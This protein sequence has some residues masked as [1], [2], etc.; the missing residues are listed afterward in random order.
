MG[1]LDGKVVIVTGM[2]QGMGERHAQWCVEQGAR[3][4]GT[5]VRVEE[6]TKA[7]TVLGER[8][9][10]VAHDV[11]D[12]DQWAAVVATAEGEWGRVDGLVNNAAVI[13]Y[14][15]LVDE[16]PDAIE[17]IW[18]VN[19]MGTWNGIR[20]VT[21]ALRRAG[22]GSIVNISSTAGLQAITHLS[23][24]GISKWA[25]RGLTKYAAAELG[26]FGIRVN[27]VHPGGIE[28]TGMFSPSD[29]DRDTHRA[30]IPLRRFGHRDDISN[31]VGFL[32]SDR[33]TFVTGVEHVVDGGSV[34]GR[35]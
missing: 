5:D 13:T 8:G 34:L 35:Y 22:G 32:L 12:P 26:P 17:R 24:Y 2:A 1:E 6:G 25:V 9:R 20:A 31:V 28:E 11:T 21:P 23:S 33:S 10:F 15:L 7:A 27:S 14:A 30:H 16:S 29:E 18:R 19:V 3:V 4:V